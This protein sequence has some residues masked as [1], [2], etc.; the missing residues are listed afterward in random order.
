MNN[1]GLLALLR[2][3]FWR[4]SAGR[5]GEK[6][7]STAAVA[8][9]WVWLSSAV[10]SSGFLSGRGGGRQRRIG[11]GRVPRAPISSGFPWRYDRMEGRGR[12]GK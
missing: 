8:S 4:L 12:K 2:C 5:G 10:A 3:V 7:R 1:F 11:G 6:R 9:W